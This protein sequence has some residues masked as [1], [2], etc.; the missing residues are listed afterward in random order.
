MRCIRDRR[1]HLNGIRAVVIVPGRIRGNSTVIIALVLR[2]LNL[3]RAIADLSEE[4]GWVRRIE[5]DQAFNTAWIGRSKHPSNA[6]TPV[7][8]HEDAPLTA[9]MPKQGMY[10]TQQSRHG[11]SLDC[12][13][14]I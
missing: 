11:L 13:R 8:A 2:C 12:L 10:I 7:I 1:R 5:D 4:Y 14:L 6:A 9:E 3:R